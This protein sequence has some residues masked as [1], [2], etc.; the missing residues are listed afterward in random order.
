MV[1]LATALLVVL[2][3]GMIAAQLRYRPDVETP[4]RRRLRWAFVFGSLVVAA[5]AGSRV[6]TTL[7]LI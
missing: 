6:A 5:L 4:W 3:V 7:G 2:S 1:T